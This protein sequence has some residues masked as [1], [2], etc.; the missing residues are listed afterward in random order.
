MHVDEKYESLLAKKKFVHLNL[1][2][3]SLCQ[4]FLCLVS[5]GGYIMLCCVVCNLGFFYFFCYLYKEPKFAQK[6]FIRHLYPYVSF[7]VL[8]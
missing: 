5:S 7:Q 3:I 6:V 2:V 1:F 8:T 4:K